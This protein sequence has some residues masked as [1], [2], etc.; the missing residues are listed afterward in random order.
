MR[1][2]ILVLFIHALWVTDVSAGDTTP[3]HSAAYTGDEKEVVSLLEAG[4]D[5][6]ARDEDLQTPIHKAI[7]GITFSD[8]VRL[9]VVT[10]LLEAG[11]NV[12]TRDEDGETPLHLAVRLDRSHAPMYREVV[13]LLEAGANPNL[14]DYNR[15]TALHLHVMR[16]STQVLKALLEAGAKRNVL[17]DDG[18]S[19][20]DRAKRRLP[21][22][23][24]YIEILEN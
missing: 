17:D 11:A 21:L 16:G 6:N 23:P 8:S 22:R 20:L 4:S 19:P 9:K 2:L 3:L 14:R 7:M 15:N 1:V 12:N 5:V 10:M 18:L 24:S 13:A